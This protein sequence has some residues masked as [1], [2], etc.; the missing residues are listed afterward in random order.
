MSESAAIRRAREALQMAAIRPLYER[1]RADIA[2]A[3]DESAMAQAEAHRMSL[4][5]DRLEMALGE[6]RDGSES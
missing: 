5:I 6:T 4:R 1:E 2:A 3:L